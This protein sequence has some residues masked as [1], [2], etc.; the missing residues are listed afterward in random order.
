MRAHFNPR[1]PAPLVCSAAAPAAR[2]VRAALVPCLSALG[3]VLPALVLG[4]AAL[5]QAPVL[6]PQQNLIQR[7]A[8]ASAP[9]LEAPALPPEPGVATGRGADVQVQVA[10]LDMQ[11]NA[12]LDTATLR[13]VV[14]PLAGQTVPLARLEEVRFAVLRAYR[15]A[16]YPYVLVTV[17]VAPL[18]G[19]GNLVRLA[20]TEGFVAEVKLEG[21]IGPAA[22][23]ALLFLD[24]VKLEQPISQAA[25]ERALLLVS[26]MPGVGAQGVLRPQAGGAPGALELV[27]RLQ[28]RTFSGFLSLDNRGPA[29]LGSWQGL[30]VAGANSLTR[31]GE[32]TEISLVD[33][34]GAR[35]RFGQVSEEVF[36]GGSGLRVRLFAGA[37]EV[38]PG[39]PLSALGYRG[40]T[41][42]GG[43]AASYPLVRSRPLNLTLGGQLD[44]FSGSSALQP[45]GQP[46]TPIGHDNVR[47]ARL[48]LDG[49]VRDAW[50]LAAAG[51]A[52]TYGQ[53]R[54]HQ[55]ITALG[56]TANGAATVQRQGSDFGFTKVTGEV[57]R[58][59][60]LLRPTEGS[61]L[62]L[63]MT[64][65]GQYSNAIL[66]PSEKFYLGGNRLG[67]GFYSGQVSGDNAV[68]GSL[69]VQLNTG[70]ALPLP[71]GT[72][73]GAGRLGLAWLD[74]VVANDNPALGLQFYGFHDQGRSFENNPKDADR[75]LASWGGGLRSILS[76][77]LQLDIEGVQRLTRTPDGNTSRQLRS[78][79]VFARLLTRF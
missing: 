23:Q 35:Q 60:P 39:S 69:E 33:S 37:G 5:A 48:S 15:Q 67:R 54:L 13:Q 56:A 6:P 9:R 61:V 46:R 24:R 17:A 18:P 8:P 58:A 42:L 45:A 73:A 26:D 74:Q 16:G 70:L 36:V 32:R 77:R 31:L 68:A 62:T 65:A 25:L 21:D 40:E 53:L 27:V 1:A 51:A 41:V 14:G 55:G 75:R 30:L 76:E 64:L 7:L 12:A 4:G 10:A 2:T 59:Q 19:G 79:A 72:A 34:A 78:E 66:P 28:R 50:A 49:A 29:N 20:I 52:S 3:L 57:T 11:G 71:R 38:V 63:Q 22:T 47:T 44:A 43:A